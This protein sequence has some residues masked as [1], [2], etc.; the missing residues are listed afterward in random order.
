MLK[1]AHHGSSGSTSRAF[2]ESVAPRLL[3]LSCGTEERSIAMDSRRLNL[4]VANTYRDGCI[5]LTFDD[6]GFTVESLR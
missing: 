3:L 5:T 4:P 1:V 6:N 2:L